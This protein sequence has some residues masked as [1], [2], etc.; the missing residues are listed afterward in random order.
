MNRQYVRILTGLLAG[1]GVVCLAALLVLALAP[2]ERTRQSRPSVDT[3]NVLPGSYVVR[4]FTAGSAAYLPRSTGPLESR[5]YL[6]RTPYPASQ[7]SAQAAVSLVSTQRTGGTTSGR[8]AR[9][10]G[11]TPRSPVRSVATRATGSKEPAPQMN[12]SGGDIHGAT[13]HKLS[14]R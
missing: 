2:T 13:V 11:H 7:R 9:R 5:E 10:V 14:S 3:S 8:P 1:F 4:P 12:A 6:T